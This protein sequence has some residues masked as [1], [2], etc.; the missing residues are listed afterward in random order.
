[1][2]Q[3]ILVVDDVASNREMLRKRLERVGYRVSEAIDGAEAV[4]LT[5]T[6]RPDLVVMDISMPDMDGMEAWRMICELEETPPPAIAVTATT[7]ADVKLTCHDIG[8]KDYLTKPLDFAE[9][10]RTIRALLPESSI[11]RV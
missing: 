1:M 11:A 5:T 10:L 9:F 2:P 4:A 3:H 6:L 7:I 8:F